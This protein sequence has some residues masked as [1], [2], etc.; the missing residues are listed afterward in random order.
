M[1][2][3]ICIAATTALALLL[4]AGNAYAADGT[5]PKHEQHANPATIAQHMLERF[6]TNGDGKLD[7]NELSAA[8]EQHQEKHATAAKVVKA[9]KTAKGS[10][11]VSDTARAEALI[12]RFD[13]DG[14]HKL[15]EAELQTML[16]TLQA[17]H[18][19]HKKPAAASL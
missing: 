12:K 4:L 14:D 6:D 15:N 8:L 18:A 13:T 5:P 10:G 9:G 1:R 7:A 3:T 16:T 17:A 19:A 11:A 2:S